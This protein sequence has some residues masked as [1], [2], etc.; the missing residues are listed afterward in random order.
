VWQDTCTHDR[1]LANGGGGD[2]HNT[3]QWFSVRVTLPTKRSGDS[4][5]VQ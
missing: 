5:V 4:C 1:G 3:D 2:V